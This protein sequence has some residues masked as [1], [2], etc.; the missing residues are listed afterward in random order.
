MHRIKAVEIAHGVSFGDRFIRSLAEPALLT[1]HI[2]QLKS[3]GLF[4]TKGLRGRD[5]EVFDLMG[6]QV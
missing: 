6:A 2:N 5:E 4:Q 1:L 3:C